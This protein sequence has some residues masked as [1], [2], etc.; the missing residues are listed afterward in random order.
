MKEVYLTKIERKTIFT[1]SLIY[2]LVMFVISDLTQTGP[3]Y[4][5]F[6]P[7]LFIL[8]I[9]AS[10]KGIDKILTCIIGGFTVFVSCIIVENGMNMV[11]VWHTLSAVLQLVFGIIA[12][13]I[14]Y[15]FILEHRLVK[16]IRTSKK[17]LYI[18]LIVVLTVISIGICSIL[19]GDIY[20]YIVSRKNLDKYISN[21]YM[22]EEYSIKEVKY[23]KKA[24]GNY[25]YKVE[26][27]KTELY[28][29]PVTKTEFNEINKKDRISKLE[30]KL[31][32]E[33]SYVLEEVMKDSL[34]DFLEV[35]KENISFRLDYSKVLLN[36][37]KA[38]MTF[39]VNTENV[40]EAIIEIVYIINNVQDM[41]V[42]T[43]ITDVILNINNKAMNIKLE[44]DVI[45]TKEY[46]SNGLNTLDLDE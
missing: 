1:K 2:V 24:I 8:G 12:G 22:V 38:I 26:I 36:P 11:V 32:Q 28:L 7:W 37:D 3:F 16:Y 31:K 14:F 33:Y 41:N 44:E 17:T 42:T 43:K 19:Y 29:Y 4:I 10:I 34:V 9:F 39:D 45:V 5:N 15:E 46:I 35:D 13:K 30:D 23:N 20:S 21:T 18:S 25:V 27:S 40:D 6:I